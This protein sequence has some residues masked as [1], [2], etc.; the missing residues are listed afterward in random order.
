MVR[1]PT[2]SSASDR[3]L[4]CSCIRLGCSCDDLLFQ[5]AEKQDVTFMK[6]EMN[7]EEDAALERR[8]LSSQKKTLKK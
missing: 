7:L 8:R 3:L 4:L 5:V 1:S 6:K 2:A